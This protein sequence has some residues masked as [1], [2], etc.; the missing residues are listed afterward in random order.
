MPSFAHQSDAMADSL[1]KAS[2]VTASSV[3][4]VIQAGKTL[5]MCCRR[6]SVRSTADFQQ[7]GTAQSQTPLLHLPAEPQ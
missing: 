3:V 7:N 2:Q 4:V 5:L 6:A 1:H